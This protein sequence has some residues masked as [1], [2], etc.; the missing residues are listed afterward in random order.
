LTTARALALPPC[1]SRLAPPPSRIDHCQRQKRAADRADEGVNGV[2][3]R[4]E[5]ENL[6]GEEFHEGRQPGRAHHPRIGKDLE[7]LQMLGQRQDLKV[8]RQ[9]C[10]QN[11]QVKAPAG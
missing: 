9:T 1:A 4:I 8:H 7:R 2:P 11:C 10:R 3:H 6:V 5:P